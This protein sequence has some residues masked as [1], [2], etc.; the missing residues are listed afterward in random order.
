MGSH[1]DIDGRTRSGDGKPS[2]GN[3]G[4]VDTSS[5]LHEEH[6]RGYFEPDDR[7][8]DG[9]GQPSGSCRFATT[10][11][12]SPATGSQPWAT[13]WS[14]GRGNRTSK[15][16]AWSHAVIWISTGPRPWECPTVS[17]TIDIESRLLYKSTV[18]PTRMVFLPSALRGKC[19][20]L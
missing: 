5:N 12:G 6:Q 18:R 2:C 16:V 10:S 11:C 15:L 19:M 20:E 7:K 13:V 8:P 4:N 17:S 3:S 9:G 14:E 1:N